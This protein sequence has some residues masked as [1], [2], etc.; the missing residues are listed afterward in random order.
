[1]DFDIPVGVNGD[2]YDRYLVRIE[3]MRQC[4]PHH[5]AVR[6]W[7]RATRAR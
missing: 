3:E 4:E 1:M 6:R 2:C 5:P 7:L